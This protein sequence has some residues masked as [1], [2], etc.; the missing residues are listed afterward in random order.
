MKITYDK[1]ADAAYIYLSDSL[2]SKNRIVNENT[3]IDLDKDGNVI[4]IELLYVSKN[5]PKNFLSNVQVED[6]TTA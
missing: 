2:F 4:G 6:I 3:I 1:E 5:F